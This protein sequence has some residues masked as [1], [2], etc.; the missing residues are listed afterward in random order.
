MKT[1]FTL[2][3][4]TTVMKKYLFIIAIT[5][6]FAVLMASCN[7]KTKTAQVPVTDTT[8]F[9][10]FKAYK[11]WQDQ[12]AI[13]PITVP[14]AA[15]VATTHTTARRSGSSSA[16]TTTMSSS[17]TNTGKVSQKKGWSKAAK[18]GVIGGGG[19]AV[20]GAV[21]NK[22]NRVAGGV[23]GGIVGGG[24]GYLFGRHKD[25]QEGRY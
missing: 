21:I 5:A 4:K 11:A 16:R 17:T 24:L 7:S 12:Q 2:I 20:L 14:V 8:G 19:G 6:A 22:R 25:K 1:N 10:D 13:A 15:P 23:V 3:K 9:A 18:Y